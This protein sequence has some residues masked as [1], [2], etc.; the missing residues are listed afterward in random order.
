MKEINLTFFAQ[1][2]LVYWVV[3]TVLGLTWRN[4]SVTRQKHKKNLLRTN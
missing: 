1:F 4:L 2:I 3:R